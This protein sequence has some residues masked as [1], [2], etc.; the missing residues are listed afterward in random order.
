METSNKKNIYIYKLSV[1]G[2]YL[3]ALV[4]TQNTIF[5]LSITMIEQGGETR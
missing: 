5:K 2:T 3:D 4:N 1:P